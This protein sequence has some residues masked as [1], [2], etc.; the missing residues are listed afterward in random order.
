MKWQS[1]A[2][3]FTMQNLKR[4]NIMQEEAPK[5]K[6]RSQPTHPNPTVQGLV[7]QQH[8]PDHPQH[9]QASKCFSDHA[10]ITHNLPLLNSE[11]THSFPLDK[12]ESNSHGF[13]GSYFKSHTLVNSFN[14]PAEIHSAST[15]GPK[16][17]IGLQLVQLVHS[18]RYRVRRARRE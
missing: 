2:H 14:F 9:H 1:D 18:E 5:P 11:I 3:K 13:K 12:R 7:L 17:S 15:C 16:R 8:Q 4:N 10:E 6:S